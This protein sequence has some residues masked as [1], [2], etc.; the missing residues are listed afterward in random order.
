MVRV[1]QAK[2]LET[3]QNIPETESSPLKRAK[4]NT[5]DGR[6][7]ANQLIGSISYPII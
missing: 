7:P 1:M 2:E 3:E 6:T 4:I 5:V